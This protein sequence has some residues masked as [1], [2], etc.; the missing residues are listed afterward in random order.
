MLTGGHDVDQGWM[1]EVRKPC[2]EPGR[3]LHRVRLLPRVIFELQG[4]DV[5]EALREPHE[6]AVLLAGEAER[7]GF[8]GWVRLCV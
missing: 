5:L 8:D 7:R 2:I 4:Q 6:V 3:P 1:A